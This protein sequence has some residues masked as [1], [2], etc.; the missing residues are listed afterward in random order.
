MSESIE[1]LTYDDRAYLAV[2]FSR[3][4]RALRIIDRLTAALESAEARRYHANE[5]AVEL[6]DR[7]EALQARVAELEAEHQRQYEAA[8]DWEKH[9]KDAERLRD[10][11]YVAHLSAQQR[12]DAAESE[13]AQMRGRVERVMQ[14][15]AHFESDLEGTTLAVALEALR[16]R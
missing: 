1:K 10:S 6:E 13:L 4:R 12:A 2:G 7:A 8:Q 3:E 11:H 5:L 16:G 14:V 15:Y 9:C